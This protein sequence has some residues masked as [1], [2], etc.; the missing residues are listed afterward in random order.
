MAI[1]QISRIQH[2]RG[3]Q[4]DL[5]NLS[6]AELGWS[7]DARRLFI[8]NGTLSEGAPVEGR[9]EILTEHTDLFA[10]FQNFQFKGEPAGFVANTSGDNEGFKRNLQEKLDDFVNV[11]D[12]G[13][14]GDGQTDDTDAIVRALNN[15]YAYSTTIGGVDMRRTIFFPAGYY[16]VS[17]T[18]KVPPFIKIQGDGKQNTIIR[19][20]QDIGPIFH[21]ADSNGETGESL[22]QQPGTIPPRARDYIICDIGI[23]N[24]SA[25]D[26]PCVIIDGGSD[27]YFVRTSFSGN[28]ASRT[29]DLGSGK[30]AVYFR[31][32]SQFFETS[33]IFF[34]HCEFHN[35]NRGVETIGEVDGIVFSS[36]QFRELVV[37]TVFSDGTIGTVIETSTS[38]NETKNLVTHR[39]T[40][41]KTIGLQQTLPSGSSGDISLQVEAYKNLVIDYVITKGEDQR[42]GKFTS[43]G[44]GSSYFF[45]DEYVESADTGVEIFVDSSTGQLKYTSV[46]SAD[47]FYTVKFYQ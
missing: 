8:G 38:D 29:Q 14:M 32:E 23:N 20:L 2:R 7:V 6:S 33:K 28:Q 15:T 35:H 16:L 44:N 10:L 30:S 26:K 19:N 37:D 46:D 40:E 9:T 4:Q 34:D 45:Q 11:R 24:R 36:C 12:F 18:I 42:T 1:I 41:N 43:S 47:I 17:D 39:G 13:A 5:P 22:G 21:F 27:F 31:S 3:L 25:S